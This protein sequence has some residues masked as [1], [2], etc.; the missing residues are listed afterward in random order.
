MPTDAKS[1]WG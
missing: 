1:F